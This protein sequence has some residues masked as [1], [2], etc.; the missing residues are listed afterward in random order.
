MLF[1]LP[2]ADEVTDIGVSRSYA[3]GL[4]SAVDVEMLPGLRHEPLNEVG[5]ERVFSLVGEWLAERVS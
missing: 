4:G 3:E 1:L 2:E 5:R